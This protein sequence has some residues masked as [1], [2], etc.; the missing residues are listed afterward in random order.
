[1]DLNPQQQL[2]VEH[3]DGPLLILAGPG[4]GKTRVL[5]NRIVHLIECGAA[6]PSEILAVTFT[7]KAADEMRR[8]I[9][10]LVGPRAREIQAGT[11]HS[12]CLKT[13]RLHSEAL[14]FGNKFTVF[15][16]A[17]QTALVKECLDSLNLS[18]ERFQPQSVV[19]RISR[20]KDSCLGPGEFA[21]EARGNFYL[22][23][24]S[25]IY[26][27]YQKRLTELQAMDF[28]DLIRLAVKLLNES[29]QIL[30]SYQG[31]FRF[32][33]VDEYQDTNRAQYLLLSLLAGRHKNICVVGD[34]D[35]SVYRWR[36]ADISNILRFEK[37]YPGTR[38]IKLEQNYRSTPEILAAAGGVIENNAGR[39][40]KQIWTQN[41]GGS[42]IEIFSLESERREAELVA[43]KIS[44][45]CGS[46]GSRLGDFAIFYR[47]N[48]QSRPF[49]DI[50][51]AK[52]ISYRIF[53]GM[54]FYERAE[55][56]DA[57]AYL[58]LIASP[59]DDI[60]FR[61]II[62]VPARGIGKTTL[63]KLNQFASEK[64]ICLLDAIPQ[65]ANSG[66]ISNS[67]ATRLISF[68]KMIEGLKT[69]SS[70]ASLTALLHDMLERSGYIETLVKAATIE[71]EARLE[72]LNELVTAV[73]EF[74]PLNETNALTEFL[75]QVA[76]VS[77]TDKIGEED[78]A[79]TMM[80]LHLAKG[81][82]FP[83][84]F[85]VGME[86]GLFPHSRSLDDPEELKEE[87]RLC[88]VGMTRA[89][90]KLVLSHAF[91]RRLFGQERY[92]VASRFLDEIGAQ[93]VAKY[94]ALVTPYE[95]RSRRHEASY[96]A[97]RTAGFAQP[98]SD[99]VS[100]F[101][102]RPP[103]ERIM[104]ASAARGAF[105]KGARVR[106]PTFGVGTIAV[107]EKTSIG[108]KVTVK[109]SSGETKR[110]IAEFAGLKIV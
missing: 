58:R 63:D 76:L 74:L 52:G 7:N 27:R 60:S 34:D 18:R 29:E 13:L 88:Y 110:L 64:G 96:P 107:S 10:S 30:E 33:M 57:I 39:K 67:T 72:N 49:E 65:F 42:K 101:D 48:A 87:R 24:I 4:S 103:E 73:E 61:R 46:N 106:H 43:D 90:K 99:F 19:D 5:V 11:F 37:D 56:K 98:S 78:G 102:Q 81:L 80:T 36:G 53:G 40:S 9:E 25:K 68:E 89:K 3:K 83:S 22:E 108:H 12:F 14:G 66:L 69:E 1:M 38:V 93:Y 94:S 92:N 21:S 75:D 82:E 59:T 51:R 62:N 8:R 41:P 54:R 31:R 104:S 45:E 44:K 23:H 15:D 86:E 100:D 97:Y 77:E 91:R 109:F 85:I 55:I 84:V 79:V 71:A 50:F 2:A 70:S 20:A 28:G 105:P 6:F 17:D 95:T 47:T 35:Q 32:I 16:E 26:E